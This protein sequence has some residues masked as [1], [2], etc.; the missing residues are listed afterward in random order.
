MNYATTGTDSVLY[1]IFGFG[2]R[3]ERAS[4]CAPQSC[5]VE[6]VTFR[7]DQPIECPG[8]VKYVNNFTEECR[9]Y[10]V[11]P[12]NVCQICGMDP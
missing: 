4:H 9:D 6:W 5:Q 10:V 2:K 7:R 8:I 3:Y 11:V 1:E 12:V